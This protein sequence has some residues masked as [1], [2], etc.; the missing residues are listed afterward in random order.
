LALEE[1]NGH[2]YAGT[3][4]NWAMGQG[5][6]VYRSSDGL[7]WSATSEPGFGVFTDTVSAIIDLAVFNGRLYAAAG[8]GDIQGQIWRS[9]DGENWEPV[10]EDGFGNGD[11]NAVTSLATFNG[12]LYAGA[13]NAVSGAQIWRSASGDSGDWTQVAPDEPGTQDT[14]QVTGFTIFQ[15]KLYA[16]VEAE[17]EGPGPAQVWRSTN[18]SSWDTVVPDGF[19]DADNLSTGGFAIFHDYLYVGTR[20][21]VSGAQLWRTADGLNWQPVFEDGF[22]NPDN[23]MLERLFVFAG[24]L[25]A[26]VDNGMTGLEMRRTPDGLDWEQVNLGGFGDSNNVAT[27]W[28]NAVAVYQ[29]QFYMGT[30][31]PANG[32]EIW[33]FV[34]LEQRQ[35]LPVV[36]N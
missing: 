16:A 22:G 20:N 35:H 36:R 29:Q 23:Y 14:L 21:H 32:G 34:L 9:A 28:N 27:L 6:R 31:N 13:G 4:T 30:W 11:N 2:L 10:V 1:F 15:D 18:G 19:G 17:W 33:R 12:L 26:G 7:D 8:W 5:A 25:Y 3:Q 24:Q